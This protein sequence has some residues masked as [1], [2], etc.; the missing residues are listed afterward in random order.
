[1]PG[2]WHRPFK[3]AESEYLEGGEAIPDEIMD[4]WICERLGL[5]PKELDEMGV[6]EVWRWLGYRHGKDV[7][8]HGHL[9]G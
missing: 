1:V 6:E 8:G 3:D 5:K 4:C 7:A 9:T 2:K